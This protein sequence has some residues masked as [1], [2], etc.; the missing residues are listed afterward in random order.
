MGYEICGALGVQLAE[1]EK[2][3]YAMVGDG[4]FLRLHSELYTAVQEGAKT[5][6]YTHLLLQLLRLPAAFHRKFYDPTPIS[7]GS[8]HPQHRA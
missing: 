2:E 6:S 8:R 3:V 4:S 5:V 1:P 7:R